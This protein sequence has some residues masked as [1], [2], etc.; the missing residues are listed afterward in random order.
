[1]LTVKLFEVLD[2]GTFIP[3]MATAMNPLSPEQLLALQP[4]QPGLCR[5]LER[6][7]YLLRRAGFAYARPAAA[8]PAGETYVM[9]TSLHKGPSTYNAYDWV[10]E[11]LGGGRTMHEAH[12][13]IIEHWDELESGAVVDVRYILGETDKPKPSEQFL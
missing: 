5:L 12:K 9:L 13:Y 6:E 2:E 8:Y 10:H 11:R 4:E 7:R 1:M 3:V